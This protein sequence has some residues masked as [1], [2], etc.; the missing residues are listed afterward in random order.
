MPS[1]VLPSMAA[2][3]RERPRVPVTI[4]AA[5]ASVA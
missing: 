1:A 3:A 4:I 5:S 2:T